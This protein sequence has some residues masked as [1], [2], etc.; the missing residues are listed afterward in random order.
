MRRAA[1]GGL[2]EP[3]GGARRRAELSVGVAP[4][5]HI[6]GPKSQTALTERHGTHGHPVCNC[7]FVCVCVC[8]RACVCVCACACVCVYVTCCLL[9]CC[10]RVGHS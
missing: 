3:Q 5:S 8:A 9:V 10:L 6:P 1:R 7:M 2:R 4:Y